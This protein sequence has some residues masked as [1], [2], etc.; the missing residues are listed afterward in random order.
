MA[1][2]LNYIII[3]LCATVL[4]TGCKQ[5]AKSSI[6][7]GAK[8]TAKEVIEVSGEK[9]SKASART[10]MKLTAEMLPKDRK[11]LAVV[12]DEQGRIVPAINNLNTNAVNYTDAIN[13]QLL[14][15]RRM[16]ISP[17]DQFPTMAQLKNYDANKL[18]LSDK[19]SADLLR[20]NLYLVMN[21][22]SVD[23]CKGFGGTAAHHV[24]EGT[25]KYAAKS[26]AILKKF[27]I[28]INAPE[29]GILLPDGE[30]SIYKGC[31]HRTRHTPEYSEYVYNKVK[32]A[33]TRDELIALLSEIK[34]ELY[35]GKLSLQG[36]AQG[37]N[38]NS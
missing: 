20:R 21:P 23:I 1:M 31:M 15:T 5:V 3:A 32:D 25:D 33:Q 6:K 36:P 10:S 27:N 19:P 38:K 11:A 35:N 22:Q 28:N 16:A 18:F 12:K 34:H 24:I 8:E 17:Y 30:N 29:N 9:T 2:R 4:L 26:R 37:I 14:R 7:K 13:K